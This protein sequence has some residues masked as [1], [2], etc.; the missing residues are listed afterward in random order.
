MTIIQR[1]SQICFILTPLYWRLYGME[2]H[3]IW[4][5][6]HNDVFSFLLQLFIRSRNGN[7]YARVGIDRADGFVEISVEVPLQFPY[8]L[9]GWH[10]IVLLWILVDGIVAFLNANGFE[11]IEP[12][13]VIKF[14]NQARQSAKLPRPSSD[15][16][17]SG[18]PCHKVASSPVACGFLALVFQ[19]G[20]RFLGECPLPVGY[21]LAVAVMMEDAEGHRGPFR[22]RVTPGEDGRPLVF[23]PCGW[24]TSFH[25]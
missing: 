25:A 15:R 7:Q 6:T 22:K 14:E 9:S 20:P 18:K 1:N 13:C 16:D 12:V 17:V 3:Y 4:L 24:L 11:C 10:S 8:L 5:N 19:N 21:W 2:W 23:A